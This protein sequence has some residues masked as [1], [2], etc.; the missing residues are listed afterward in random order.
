MDG[1]NEKDNCPL[2]DVDERRILDTL[3]RLARACSGVMN[4]CAETL[5]GAAAGVGVAP[6]GTSKV[7]L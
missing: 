5:G 4:R 2:E 3:T 1:V 7:A 6:I